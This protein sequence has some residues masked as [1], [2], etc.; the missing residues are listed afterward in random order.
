MNADAFAI[1]DFIKTLFEKHNDV[2]GFVGSERKG[3]LIHLITMVTQL[4]VR[5]YVEEGSQDE[6][7]ALVMDAVR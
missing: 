5:D 3:D 4:Y 7:Y 2:G 1:R 6:F